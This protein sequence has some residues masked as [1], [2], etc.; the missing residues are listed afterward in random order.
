MPRISATHDFKGVISLSSVQRE[1]VVHK[2]FLSIVLY[3]TSELGTGIEIVNEFKTR[4][5]KD[6]NGVTSQSL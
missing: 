3:F 5:Q 6:T 2:Q 4:S 1:G